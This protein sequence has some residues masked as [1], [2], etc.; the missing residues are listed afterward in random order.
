[1]DSATVESYLQ[2][3]LEK[4][5]ITILKPLFL[6]FFSRRKYNIQ[7]TIVLNVCYFSGAAFVCSVHCLLSVCLCLLLWK[8]FHE[9]RVLFEAKR[10]VKSVRK[11]KGSAVWSAECYHAGLTGIARKNIQEDFMSGQLRVVVATVAFGMGL[12]KSN[13]RGVVHFN[14]PKNIESYIQEIGRAGRD[15]QTAFCHLF[16]DCKVI[17]QCISS[18]LVCQKTLCHVL[19]FWATVCKMVRPMLS[20]CCL[21]CPVRDVGVLW[22]NSW[23]DTDETWHAGRPQ[24]RSPFPKGHSPPIF[25]PYLLWQM[26]RWIK[27]PLGRKVGL[28]PSNIVFDG[29]PASSPPKK[30]PPPN[31]WHMSIVPKRLDGSICHLVWR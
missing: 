12:D 28:D 14:M 20:D 31:F 27:M 29:D 30:S 17:Q 6:E 15:G 24:P 16:L 1:M 18:I 8:L 7:A 4:H 5:L 13:I 22:P 26:A 3:W 10:K 23:T 11:S 25:G 19:S 2:S 9:C 21:S